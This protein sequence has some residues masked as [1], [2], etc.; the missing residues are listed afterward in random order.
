MTALCTPQCMSMTKRWKV[1]VE[2]ACADNWI[3]SGQRYV[4][5]HSLSERIAE[6]MNMACMQSSSKR[7]CLLDSYG[8]TGSDVIPVDCEALPSDPW[9]LD[10]GDFANNQSRMST[11][12]D[13]NLLCSEC[14]LKI[15]HARVTSEFL[16][17]TDYADYLVDEFQD[18][19]SVCKTKVG[20]LTTRMAPGYPHVTDAAAIGRPMG[21]PSPVT[22]TPSPSATAC[23]GRMVELRPD[24]EEFLT[25]DDIASRFSVATGDIAVATNNF[26][27]DSKGEVCIPNTCEVYFVGN[28]DT[29]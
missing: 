22:P 26:Y 9:C 11:L 15:L 25:C 14:F 19:Q 18:I 8:W 3:R 28:N 4:P 6:G 27:C 29:W 5:A 13:D 17:D 20:E 2:T 21:T 16:Q 24:P 10:R 23:G 12:Y 1:Q 7:W